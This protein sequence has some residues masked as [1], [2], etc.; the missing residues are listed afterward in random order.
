AS[1]RRV[2]QPVGG[3][4][5]LYLQPYVARPRGSGLRHNRA[6]EDLA[7]VLPRDAPLRAFVGGL[8]PRTPIRKTRPASWAPAASG[9]A[10]RVR[11]TRRTTAACS[12]A[13]GGM[14]CLRCDDVKTG[15]EHVPRFPAGWCSI[16]EDCRL[17]ATQLSAACRRGRHPMGYNGEDEG[18]GLHGEVAGLGGAPPPPRAALPERVFGVGGSR[19]GRGPRR[20]AP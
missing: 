1:T 9:A 6:P 17:C 5:R 12:M 10:T 13:D 2:R 14:L 19:A 15:E 20:S 11:V 8:P 18:H 3:T 16:P 4:V 7:A